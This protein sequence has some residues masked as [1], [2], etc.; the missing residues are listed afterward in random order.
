MCATTACPPSPFLK[1][2]LFY[3]CD[4]TV[5][6]DPGGEEEV[7]EEMV[8][9]WGKGEKWGRHSVSRCS[10]SLLPLKFPVVLEILTNDDGC[11]PSCGCWELNF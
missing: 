5:A 2:Y 11:E 3:V 6:P 8:S 10:S 1:I 9:I 7:Q 4:Y